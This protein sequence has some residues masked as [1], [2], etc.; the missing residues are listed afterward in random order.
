MKKSKINEK[1]FVI[2]VVYVNTHHH[3]DGF[4]NRESSK[5]GW[6]HTDSDLRA[7]KIFNSENIALRTLNKIRED[8][9][10]SEDQFTIVPISHYISVGYVLRN[11]KPVKEKCFCVGSKLY[12][13]TGTKGRGHW[14]DYYNSY[15]IYKTAKECVKEALRDV[16]HDIKEIKEEIKRNLKELKVL[17]KKL[18]VLEKN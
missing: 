8:N 7:A 3:T 15:E 18:K 10:N 14:N 5:N 16:K 4:L 12:P 9:P 11:G 2:S 17:E 13:F 1:G 6:Y